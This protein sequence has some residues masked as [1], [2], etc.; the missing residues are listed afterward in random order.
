MA[1]R[2][3]LSH[4][5]KTRERIQTSQLI[6]RLQSYA[7]GEIELKTGQVK[8]IDILLRKTV[9]DLSAVQLTGQDGNPIETVNTVKLV[10]PNG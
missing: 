4:D 8:A 2:K 5:Q 9:P 7:K 1:A 6:N 10:G 3:H